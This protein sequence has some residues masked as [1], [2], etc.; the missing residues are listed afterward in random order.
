MVNS[1][2]RPPA[3]RDSAT[4]QRILDAAHRVFVRRGTAG[5]R[6]QE[7]ADEAGVNKALLHYY[8]RSK[9]RLALAVFQ[10]AAR[11]IFPPLAALL[12]SPQALEDKVR[13]VVAFYL[14]VL[15]RNPFLPGYLIC[16]MNHFPERMPELV[17]EITGMTPREASMRV[18]SVLR[19][20]IAERVATGE[21]RPM[22]AEQF[23]VNLVSLCIFPFAA[24]PMVCT[25]LG[26]DAKGFSAFIETRRGELADFVLAGLRP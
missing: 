8:F 16:E 5:A 26:L 25:I 22:T 1:T 21:M 11:G 17:R 14:D 6:T 2:D 12:S 7:I 24:R 13:G 3:D 15:A 19:P 23:V 18:L 9:E 20:Q 10:R 4:E